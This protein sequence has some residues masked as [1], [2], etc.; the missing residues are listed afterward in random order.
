MGRWIVAVL[1]LTVAGNPAWASGESG[2]REISNRIMELRQK[3]HGLHAPPAEVERPEPQAASGKKDA[4]SLAPGG[5]GIERS[6]ASVLVPEPVALLPETRPEPAAQDPDTISDALE[7][8]RDVQ[9]TLLFHEE[10]SPKKD[11]EGERAGLPPKPSP[12]DRTEKQTRTERQARTDKPE[13]ARTGEALTSK[14]EPKEAA[15]ES[16]IP[17]PESSRDEI[18]RLVDQLRKKA[19]N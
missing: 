3:L 8:R 14:A 2:A 19:A 6:E 10:G 15:K 7:H 9:V 16:M 12:A 1:I 13:Q 11:G 4:P 18:S 17:V 5:P